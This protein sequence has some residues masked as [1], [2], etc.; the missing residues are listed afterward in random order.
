MKDAFKMGTSPILKA[1]YW[2]C[3]SV[4]VRWLIALV[5]NTYYFMLLYLLF[6]FILVLVI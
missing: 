2:L 5:M 4:I 3:E 6:F 1:S